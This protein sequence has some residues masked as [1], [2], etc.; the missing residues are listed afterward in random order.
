[1]TYGV[2][3]LRVLQSQVQ[4]L[5]LGMYL[6]VSGTVL[7]LAG[8]ASSMQGGV[9]PLAS[10]KAAQIV[11]LVNDMFTR[12]ERLDSSVNAPECGYSSDK[13]AQSKRALELTGNTSNDE[14]AL[15][16]RLWKSS[17]I[18]G[19]AST[20]TRC[21]NKA[22]SALEKAL[23]KKPVEAQAERNSLQDRLI[24]ASDQ[25]CGLYKRYLN[26]QQSSTNFLLGSTSLVLS[27]VATNITD[28]VAAKNYT[29]GALIS[30]GLAA[31]YNTD[32]FNSQMVFAIG[33]AIDATREETLNKLR[34]ERMGKSM[35][36]YGLSAAIGDA[37]RY[38]ELCSLMGGLAHMDKSVFVVSDPG[39]KHIARWFPSGSLMVKDG[40]ISA[41]NVQIT[42]SANRASTSISLPDLPSMADILFLSTEQAMRDAL[43]E[44]SA[45]IRRVD[46]GNDTAKKG[47]QSTAAAAVDEPTADV[48]RCTGL[49]ATL[50]GEA[51]ASPV[52]FCKPS[53]LLGLLSDSKN[54]GDKTGK[55]C[56]IALTQTLREKHHLWV[57]ALKT[58]PTSLASREAQIAFSGAMQAHQSFISDRMEPLQQ[59]YLKILKK[60]TD[61]TIGK[62]SK[63]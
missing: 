16:S 62:I 2:F 50:K 13:S 53:T 42:E 45:Q 14:Y 18:P 41:T 22:Q 12:A 32:M 31:E 26:A 40:V 48:Q 37:L 1:M 56:A 23:Q 10:P 8:C 55:E 58:D 51:A 25:S 47:A 7:L 57:L 34:R 21:M 43:K 9:G 54:C 49:E 24:V 46:T 29:T 6:M 19:D 5:I 59:G 60:F 11:D 52:S 44:A 35:A 61:D 28:A 17:N 63:P 3:L 15:E 39:L 30:S 27:A 33:K 4:P 38:H 36:E 20:E